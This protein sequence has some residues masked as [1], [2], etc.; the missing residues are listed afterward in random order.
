VVPVQTGSPTEVT[1]QSLHAV[2]NFYITTELTGFISNTFQQQFQMAK[3][4]QKQN[5]I[6]QKQ[7]ATFRFVGA[8]SRTYYKI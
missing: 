3:K 6:K 1:S 2:I 8:S 4:A 7:P 5:E